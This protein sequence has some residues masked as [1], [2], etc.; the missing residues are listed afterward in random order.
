MGYLLTLLL[1]NLA[2]VRA[3]IKLPVEQ[4][5]RDHSEYEME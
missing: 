3:I 1:G 4:L 5:N 2:A